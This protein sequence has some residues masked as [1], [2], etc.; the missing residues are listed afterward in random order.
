MNIFEKLGLDPSKP[1]DVIRAAD[2]LKLA[3]ALNN[4][5]STP[6]PVNT[7]PRE[8][9]SPPHTATTVSNG[10]NRVRTAP[11]TVQTATIVNR[12]QGASTMSTSRD[13]SPHSTSSGIDPVT[14]RGTGIETS[15]VPNAYST[16]GSIYRDDNGVMKLVFDG[17]ERTVREWARDPRLWRW[18]C[19]KG[20]DSART[21]IGTRARNPVK[22]ESFD[23]AK[24]VLTTPLTSGYK[25]YRY[26]PNESREHEHV[27]FVCSKPVLVEA[28]GE[29]KRPNQWAKDPR[30][31]EIVWDSVEKAPG[32]AESTLYRRVRRYIE[33]PDPFRSFGHCFLAPATA[34]YLH[35]ELPEEGEDLEEESYTEE[36]VE[37]KQEENAELEPKLTG[38]GPVKV[39][40]VDGE[41]RLYRIWGEIKTIWDWGRDW[42]VRMLVWGSATRVPAQP[43]GALNSR[44]LS[45]LS[46]PERFRSLG[47]AML[48]PSGSSIRVIHPTRLQAIELGIFEE[49]DEAY[50]SLAST[51]RTLQ[52]DSLKNKNAPVNGHDVSNVPAP[53][54]TV[55]APSHALPRWLNSHV[56]AQREYAKRFY[57]KIT[58][59]DKEL[60]LA[61]WAKDPELQSFVTG[62]TFT[63]KNIVDAFEKLLANRY[64][65]KDYEHSEEA[66]AEECSSRSQVKKLLDARKKKNDE[67]ERRKKQASRDGSIRRLASG[68]IQMSLWGETKTLNEWS[69]D[70]RVVI[71][72][73]GD[74][75]ESV[76][77]K[78]AV[79]KKLKD[80]LG[81][82]ISQKT[83][84]EILTTSMVAPA[85]G[86]DTTEPAEVEQGQRARERVRPSTK[87]TLAGVTKEIHTW[88]KDKKVQ[89]AVTGKKLKKKQVKMLTSILVSRVEKGQ[90]ARSVLFAPWTGAEK[91]GL[92]V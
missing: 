82:D 46:T 26:W 62:E 55:A 53:K 7:P 35:R 61:E 89:K 20:P 90:T 19:T 49:R 27:K 65:H 38:E 81:D 51:R 60:T 78:N 39:E 52:A 88:A 3:Q 75:L 58:F 17:K 5:Q 64:F 14:G 33:N 1:E 24:K 79:Y 44:A 57:E 6:S 41:A 37:S 15:G 30:L 74:V 12:P 80:R 50:E 28:W 84:E 31:L 66:F 86:N 8:L 9:P 87:L 83:A 32:T 21:V 56:H 45:Y 69:E 36:Q 47:D 77:G 43:G 23:N 42:R 18:I 13:H 2:A 73:F 54:V 11:L 76:G 70:E 25:N 72:L 4:Q 71:A 85:N 63:E 34:P 16:D 68:K 22:I 10:T 59:C 92:G 91:K 40:F 67:T 48:S 29:V